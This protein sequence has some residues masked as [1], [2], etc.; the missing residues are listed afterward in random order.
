VKL[1]VPQ[2]LQRRH[3]GPGEVDLRD[4][5]DPH[6]PTAYDPTVYD[7]AEHD[8]YV[9]SDSSDSGPAYGGTAT[10]GQHDEPEPTDYN[11]FNGTT[12]SGGP[13]RPGGT[14]S[15]T[16][17]PRFDIRNTWQILAG[18]ILIPVGVASIILAWYGAAHARV[19][20]Q[21]IPYM[22]SGGFLGLGAIIAGALLYW[23]HWLYRIYDQADLQHQQLMR[24][25]AELRDALLGI[26]SGGDHNMNG[27][28][29]GAV[30]SRP[31]SRARFVATASGNNFHR[32]ECPIVARRPS[33]LREVASHEIQD[34]Q[35]CRICEPLTGDTQT[36]E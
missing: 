33:G 12:T 8:V 35:P 4:D 32:P 27:S 2:P 31:P 3:Q 23:A 14:G 13:G 26:A 18:S 22:V 34:L 36:I 20:Q 17:R 15:R 30:L 16:G 25:Q 7:T 24:S 1:K 6:D 19:D 5:P 28:A 29:G 21:Q 9:S 11:G 10:T